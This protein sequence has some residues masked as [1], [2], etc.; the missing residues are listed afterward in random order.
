VLTIMQRF[1]RSRFPALVLGL[2]FGFGILLPEIGHSVAHRTAAGHTAS[3]E[4]HDAADHPH[5]HTVREA[6]DHQIVMAFSAAAE[7][8]SHFDLRPTA[9]GKSSLSLLPAGV[10]ATDLTLHAPERR[11][12]IPVHPDAVPLGD[13]RHAPP[14]PSR[15]PPLS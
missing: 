4:T 10:V 5:D 15:A 9:P 7:S 12:P 1:R 8:H 11:S 13:R 6:P 3:H 14:P 2:A